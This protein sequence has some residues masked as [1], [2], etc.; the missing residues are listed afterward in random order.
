ML[1]RRVK[2]S[3]K[4]M[5]KI[6]VERD[7]Y[8]GDWENLERNWSTTEIGV[9][10]KEV[11]SLL[12]EK[13]P[14]RF[15]SF[16]P[17]ENENWHK[18]FSRWGTQLNV[19]RVPLMLD[20][21][22]LNLLPYVYYG[23][24]K[25]AFIS[26]EGFYDA[27]IK[28][29][30][31]EIYEILKSYSRSM[32]GTSAPNKLLPP[33][34]IFGD[35]GYEK[36][37]SMYRKLI[38]DLPDE[39]ENLSNI[40]LR[41]QCT[42]IRIKNQES[43]MIDYWCK[44]RGTRWLSEF[45]MN[46]PTITINLVVTYLT[47]LTTRGI[48]VNGNVRKKFRHIMDTYAGSQ[49]VIGELKHA[50]AANGNNL[51]IIPERC[52]LK[53]DIF[54]MIDSAITTS[55]VPLTDWGAVTHLVR[56]LS[57]VTQ[58]LS[59]QATDIFLRNGDLRTLPDAHPIIQSANAIKTIITII[60]RKDGVEQVA[61]LVMRGP[62]MSD[63]TKFNIISTIHEGIQRFSKQAKIRLIRAYD[64]VLRD[65]RWCE[66]NFSATFVI[67]RTLS[68]ISRGNIVPWIIEAPELANYNLIGKITATRALSMN[69]DVFDYDKTVDEREMS[70]LQNIPVYLFS[71]KDFIRLI[72]THS[73][74]VRFNYMP[75]ILKNGERAG[76]L[77]T[78][79]C[80]CC[81]YN[82]E[83]LYTT[84]VTKKRYGYLLDIQSDEIVQM[85]VDEIGEV[86][87]RYAKKLSVLEKVR[88]ILLYREKHKRK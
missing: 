1:K 8:L 76:Y 36:I 62:T 74:Y 82:T 48:A 84:I 73:S 26:T 86:D 54:K 67:R 75:N 14:D 63:G 35:R 34:W 17:N 51:G 88:D 64:I 60:S 32:I 42:V 55:E 52:V 33:Y 31:N 24:F 50:I 38:I 77:M 87:A 83:I 19:T 18:F 57:D 71:T 10:V 9:I 78:D 2:M 66:D 37:V 65:E 3:P 39:Y 5:A 15:T 30:D 56:K 22:W 12:R 81:E 11:I 46:F 43:C 27:S 41:Y 61:S 80:E 23:Q 21:I 45:S 49:I 53:S 29:T 69:R 7:G 68:N 47:M 13:Y 4:L 58:G 25:N 70:I 59:P 79:F 16:Y 85:L 28:F 6:I 72:D 44:Y 20:V 40:L